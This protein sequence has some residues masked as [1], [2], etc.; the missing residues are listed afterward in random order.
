MFQVATVHELT[1]NLLRSI[2]ADDRF[3]EFVLVGGTALALQ[4]GHRMSVDLDFFRHSS[5][6]LKS[7]S[8]ILADFG[9]V[10]IDY[11]SPLIFNGHINKIKVDFVSYPYPFIGLI[12]VAEGLRVASVED[13][14]AMKLAAITNR[15]TKKDFVDLYFLLDHFSLTEMLSFY[16][17]KFHDGNEWM[18]LRSLGYF[19][20][21]EIDPMPLVLGESLAWTD[22]KSKIAARLK[23]HLA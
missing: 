21:A 19:D 10:E 1:L 18:V 2:Q 7:M 20:D 3:E 4:L 17:A 23:A 8:V 15:G 14:A 13:I 12:K 9:E 16:K 22:V 6:T 5:D 11:E